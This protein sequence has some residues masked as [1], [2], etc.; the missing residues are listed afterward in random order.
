M[1]AGAGAA[2]ETWGAVVLT[3]RGGGP[4]AA[5]GTREPATPAEG[6]QVGS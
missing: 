1:R 5:P 6:R 2:T 4:V 3:R